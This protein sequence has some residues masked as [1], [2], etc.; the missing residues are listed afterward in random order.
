MAGRMISH[1]T[2]E[3]LKTQIL[4]EGFKIFTGMGLKFTED[5]IDV[6]SRY[7][8][9]IIIE[10]ITKI[11]ESKDVIIND[12]KVYDYIN[13]LLDIIPGLILS[14]FI[15]FGVAIYYKPKRGK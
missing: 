1:M 13:V 15:N 7:L 12:D 2:Q 8:D 6:L 11:E 10:H 3:L 9:T 4:T 14:S 5:Q